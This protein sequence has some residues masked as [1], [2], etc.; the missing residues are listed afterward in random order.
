VENITYLC[1]KVRIENE[2]AVTSGCYSEINDGRM[3]QVCVC[4]SRA[5]HTP[6]NT[7]VELK[8]DFIAII[9]KILMF[10]LLVYL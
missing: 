3:V 7:A 9:L 8:S 4:E 1:T 6:C 5:G 10:G 2:D